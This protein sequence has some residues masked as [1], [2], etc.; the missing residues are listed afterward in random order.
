M[1]QM[2]FG[3]QFICYISGSLHIRLS[4]EMRVDALLGYSVLN[5]RNG[6]IICISEGNCELLVRS[7]DTEE[8]V[9]R[10]T[11]RPGGR[12]PVATSK[13]SY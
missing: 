1:R 9:A 10:E 6:S 2:F 7:L 13:L 12:H 11:R 3:Q 8:G 4:A 5:V